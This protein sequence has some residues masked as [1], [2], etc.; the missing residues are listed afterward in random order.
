[1]FHMRMKK[2]IQDLDY[3]ELAALQKD[4]QR[5][6]PQFSKMIEQE[7]QLRQ[8]NHGK[9]CV[10]CGQEL[11]L[12]SKENYTLLFGPQ[13]LKKQASFCGFDCLV[14]FLGKI[15]QYQHPFSSSDPPALSSQAS[16]S[17]TSKNAHIQDRK[18]HSS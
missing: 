3:E 1:M 10:T 16:G 6:V 11:Q 9:V 12:E 4:L 18:D 5:P 17:S 13:S 14:Y 2:I 15:K 8:K 7:L